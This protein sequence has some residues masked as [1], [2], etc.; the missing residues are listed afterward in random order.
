LKEKAGHADGKTLPIN[1]IRS[2][3]RSCR[4]EAIHNDQGGAREV[5]R[6]YGVAVPGQAVLR[7]PC[8]PSRPLRDEIGDR[9]RGARLAS[10]D[11]A[12]TLRGPPGVINGIPSQCGG[13]PTN[14]G[15]KRPSKIREGARYRGPRLA[16]G[17]RHRTQSG[18]QFPA[19][20]GSSG[21]RDLHPHRR[22][23]DAVAL[24]VIGTPTGNRGL[25]SRRGPPRRSGPPL[26]ARAANTRS[27]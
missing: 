2:A 6:L 27:S 16:T 9:G 14:L 3:V 7:P 22:S 12:P 5:I 10:G 15:R 23:R 18:E 8:K 26:W 4:K 13:V 19:G 25:L 24:Q 11:A 20:G 1:A 17:S 21:L